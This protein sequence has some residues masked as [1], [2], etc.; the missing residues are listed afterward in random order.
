MDASEQ[1]AFIKLLGEPVQKDYTRTHILPSLVIAQGILESGWGTSEL[2]KSSNNL[3]GRRGTYNGKSV[4]RIDTEIGKEGER[5]DVVVT[6]R[7]YPTIAESIKDHIESLLTSEIKVNGK[8]VKRYQ[9]VMDAKTYKDGALALKASG[10]AADIDYPQKLITI[11]EKYNLHEWDK[12]KFINHTVKHGD[13]VYRLASKYGTTAA[14]IKSWN[15][16]NQNYTIFVGQKL[17]VK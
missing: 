9:R 15:Q 3:F 12:I 17:R 4:Q 7:K 10:Y 14:Q 1:T 2:T 8:P 13:T 5:N 11:I 16:L 6:Y